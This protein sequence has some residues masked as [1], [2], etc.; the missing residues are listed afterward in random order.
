MELFKQ[1]KINIPLIEAIQRVLAY[2]KY[3][4]DLLTVKRKSSVKKKAYLANQVSSIINHELPPKFKDHGIPII[5]CVI[6]DY[7]VNRVLLDLGASVNL[8]LYSVYK[9]LGLGELKPINITLQLADRS[10]KFLRRILEDVLVKVDKF[11]FLVDFV[12]LD[13]EPVGNTKNQIPVIFG[14]PFLATIDATIRIRSGLMTVVFGNMTLN[15][16]IFS[17]LACHEEIGRAHV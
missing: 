16:K 5:S 6:S 9:Q 11:V 12:I 8:L 15:I 14:R 13:I 3:I 10:I 2:S 4:K 7:I 17:N 1:V